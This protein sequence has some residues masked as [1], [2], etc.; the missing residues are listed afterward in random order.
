MNINMKSEIR[1]PITVNKPSSKMMLPARNM[2]W[3]MREV[4]RSG[5]TVGRLRT[6][7]TMMLPD[8]T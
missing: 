4:S 8:T 6:T 2:S 3:L 7:D 5:P 1:V